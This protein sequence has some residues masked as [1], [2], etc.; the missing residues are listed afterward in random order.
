M[1]AQGIQCQTKKCSTFSLS[2]KTKSNSKKSTVFEMV[3]ERKLKIGIHCFSSNLEY[4]KATF[5]WQS[6][7]TDNESFRLFAKKN[8][9]VTL[10]VWN[11]YSIELVEYSPLQALGSSLLSEQSGI[12]LQYLDNGMHVPFGHFHSDTLPINSQKQRKREK[13]REKWKKSW[14]NW[15]LAIN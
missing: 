15:V 6:N 1:C 10:F 14:P 12:P 9:I 4:Q 3:K 8:E 13:E 11:V 2:N 7:R 5:H